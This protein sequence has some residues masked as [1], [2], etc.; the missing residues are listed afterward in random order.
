MPNYLVGRRETMK[1]RD[2]RLGRKIL[3]GIGSALTMLL[4]VSLTAR[5]DI[6]G[7]VGEGVEAA[8]GNKLRSELL[9]REVDHL[10]WAQNVGSYVHDETKNLNVELDP[11]QCGLGKWY[12]GSGR[13]GAESLLADLKGPLA[14]LEDPHRRL[15]ASAEKIRQL[16]EAGRKDEARAVYQGETMAALG[17]VQ[18]LLKKVA[19]L[20]REHILT[21]DVMGPFS[22]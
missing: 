8:A 22:E 12:Y 4:V 17:Q 9:Q 6:G 2:I 1:W 16:Y 21:E 13:Q 15:H 7:I 14:S 19:D 11:T 18:E 5:Y 10:K 3:I 20:S